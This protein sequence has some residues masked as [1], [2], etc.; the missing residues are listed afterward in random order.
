M[1]QVAADA[2]GVSYDPATPVAT[3]KMG[4]SSSGSS[5]TGVTTAPANGAVAI[6]IVPMHLAASLAVIG[7]VLAGA[8]SVF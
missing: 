3:P 5:S 7:G 6:Q 1:F 4:S 8:L 2:N